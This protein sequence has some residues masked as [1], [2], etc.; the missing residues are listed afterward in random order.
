MLTTSPSSPSSISAF[1]A[2][3]V[4]SVIALSVKLM[5][6]V[7]VSGKYFISN[8]LPQRARRAHRLLHTVPPALTLRRAGAAAPVL[9]RQYRT[10]PFIAYQTRVR[11]NRDRAIF[12]E[13]R[14]KRGMRTNRRPPPC[15]RRTWAFAIFC[16]RAAEAASCPT[17]A[18][19]GNIFT[20]DGIRRSPRKTRAAISLLPL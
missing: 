5:R 20:R 14:E 19:H 18:L 9:S 7:S 10:T 17:R 15:A 4:V 16:G 2:A 1:S 6:R 8:S 11:E 3:S 12:R 13:M